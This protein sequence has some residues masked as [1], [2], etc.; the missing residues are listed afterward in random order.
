MSKSTNKI[1]GELPVS[2]SG[3]G[4][5]TVSLDHYEDFTKLLGANRF[6]DYPEYIFR[7]HRDPSWPLLPSLYRR[8]AD[9]F[10]T[11]KPAKTKHL[12]LDQQ[13]R[14][15]EKTYIILKHYLFGLRGTAW[16]EP[17][18]EHLIHWF[19]THK[20]ASPH[21]NDLWIDGK[22]DRLLWDAAINTWATGQHY[23]LWTP[24]LD[25]T[26]SP[27]VAFYFAFEQADQ[28]KAGEESRV[29]Y[30]LNRKLIEERCSHQNFEGTPLDFV[31]PFMRH[32]PRLIAQQGLF[33][34]SHT[35]ES[36]EDWVRGS[37]KGEETP[38]LIRFLIRNVPTIDAVRWLNR[39]GINDRNLFPDLDGIA[40][41]TN[42]IFDDEKLD[43]IRA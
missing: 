16:H 22:R 37:F 20:S 39:H 7:G 43:Y 2:D 38:V 8:I 33:T 3:D 11:E 13:M 19:E 15:G 6:R 25:W 30:A 18:H 21:I 26:E 17:H 5:H 1:L 10:S 29:V 23:R 24:L 28:R 9:A 14:A 42:R 27:L 31:T 34:Y 4:F 35:Y 40:R 12:Q 32:N 36:V 41:F